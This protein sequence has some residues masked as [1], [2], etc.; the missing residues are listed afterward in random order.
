MLGIQE[1]GPFDIPGELARE[2]L[3]LPLNPD[4]LHNKEVLK[5]Y[6]NGD[7]LT[8]RP[9]DRWIIDIQTTYAN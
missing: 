2:W 9:R 4:G 1:S 8:E 7:D 6:W 5:P 3:S